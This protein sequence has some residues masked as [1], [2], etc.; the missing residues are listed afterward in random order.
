[1]GWPDYGRLHFQTCSFFAQQIQSFLRWFRADDTPRACEPGD[2]LEL[3]MSRVSHH[4]KYGLPLRFC[5]QILGGPA[6]HL[7]VRQ[8]FAPILTITSTGRGPA[9]T[10]GSA[11][12]LLA[13]LRM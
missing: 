12:I 3:A 7:P 10:P 8:A 5:R 1:M 9:R 6:K 13:G 2:G 4:I 11:T